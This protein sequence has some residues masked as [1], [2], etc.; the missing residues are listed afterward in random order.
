MTLQWERS[1]N[2]IEKLLVWV[3][4]RYLHLADN[5]LSTDEVESAETDL[6]T[7]SDSTTE[8]DSTTKTEAA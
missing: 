5:F 6:Q 4:D 2:P 1:T 8:P 3:E 7:E